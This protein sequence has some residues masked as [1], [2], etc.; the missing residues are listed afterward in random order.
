MNLAHIFY[1]LIFL[2]NKEQMEFDQISK[3]AK[4]SFKNFDSLSANYEKQK[5]ILVMSYNILAQKYIK[6]EY[7][8]YCPLNFLNFEYRSSI[9]MKEIEAVNPDI[10][11]L[12]ECDVDLFPEFYIPKLEYLGYECLYNNIKDEKVIMNVICYKRSDFNVQEKIIIDL[13][14]DFL[15]KNEAFDKYL[16]KAIILDLMHV[17]SGKRITTINTHLYWDPKFVFVK[18]GQLVK[19]LIDIENKY[20][21]LAPI[22]LCGDFNS[23]PD[24]NVIKYIYNEKPDMGITIEVEAEKNKFIIQEIWDKYPNKFNLRSAYDSY[25][26]ENENEF[27]YIKNHPDFTNFTLEFKG[28]LDYIIY[29]KEYF[30]LKELLKIP[31]DDSIINKSTLP[32]KYYPS[33]HLKIAARFE[34]L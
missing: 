13:K 9:I 17:P 7:F 32:N 28:N 11:C 1:F 30:K 23:L 3:E 24:S 34:L 20:S 6:P 21:L 25:K 2:I 16:K 27:D 5:S 10:L 4:I 26:C 22:I 29:S 33:D 15:H 19:I 12:Q 31:T 14:D 18:Y 8:P